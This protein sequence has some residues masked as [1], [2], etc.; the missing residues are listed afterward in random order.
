MSSVNLELLDTVALQML[1]LL[2]DVVFVGGCVA[3]ALITDEAAPHQRV[4][5]DVDTIVQITT[6]QEY[7][8][9]ASKLQG[10]GFTET[11]KQKDPICRWYQGELMLDV[12]PTDPAVLG[13]GNKWFPYAAANPE[14]YQ[15]PSK[16]AIK[17][18]SAPCFLLTKI[19]AFKTRGNNDV[20]MSHDLEDIVSVLNGRPALLKEIQNAAPQIQQ[21]LAYEFKT[22]RSRPQYINAIQAHLPPDSASQKRVVHVLGMIDEIVTL[23]GMY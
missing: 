18:I 3:T 15:L 8:T 7:H 4:T 10:L 17:I 5:K 12:M 14:N 1:P 2:K 11:T 13:F 9:F 16:Q 22:L 19:E 21:A 20:L 6:I 23:V